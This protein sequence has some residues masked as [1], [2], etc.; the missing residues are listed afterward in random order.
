MIPRQEW[1]KNRVNEVIKQLE[2]LKQIEDW[3]HYRK[4]ALELSREL[5]YAVTEW[6]DCYDE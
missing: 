6:E 5:S 3:D 2:C 1:L 4:M